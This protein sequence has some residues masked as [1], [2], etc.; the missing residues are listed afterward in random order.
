M[1]LFPGSAQPKCVS[2]KSVGCYKLPRPKQRSRAV[3]LVCMDRVSSERRTGIQEAALTQAGIRSV[4]IPRCT[5]LL[6]AGHT[7]RNQISVLA[8]TNAL[9]W[10]RE[11]EQGAAALQEIHIEMELE[12]T[13]NWDWIAFHWVSSPASNEPPRRINLLP[14]LLGS[15]V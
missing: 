11:S 8:P 5:R 2:S 14:G 9:L 3:S 15:W 4:W 13:V 10:N 7:T 12:I 1:S 6:Q